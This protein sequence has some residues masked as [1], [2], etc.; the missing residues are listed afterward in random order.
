MITRLM[1]IMSLLCCVLMAAIWASSSILGAVAEYTILARPDGSQSTIGCARSGSIYF[2]Y[3]YPNPSPA[4]RLRLRRLPSEILDQSHLSY[5]PLPGVRYTHDRL[6]EVLD[7]H[8]VRWY[9]LSTQ[10]SIHCALPLALSVVSSAYAWARWRKAAMLQKTRE[11]RCP[12][13]GYDLRA[14]PQRCPECGGVPRVVNPL[15]ELA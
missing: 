4:A 3:R 9:P 14:T 5:R 1:A 6:P 10:I 8:S 7:Q 13:C 11:G 12:T 15:G 2:G